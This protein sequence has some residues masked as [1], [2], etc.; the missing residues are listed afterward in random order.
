MRNLWWATCHNY[1][2]YRWILFLFSASRSSP[3]SL[4]SVAPAHR[5][6]IWHF[7]NWLFGRFQLSGSMKMIHAIIFVPENLLQG[8]FSDLSQYATSELSLKLIEIKHITAFS[9]PFKV[10]S[11]HADL[12][13]AT[14]PLGT[15][16]QS[17]MSIAPVLLYAQMPH[18]HAGKMR[19]NVRETFWK[20][21]TLSICSV[22]RGCK[23]H[24][25]DI[26]KEEMRMMS[27][28]LISFSDWS[29]KCHKMTLMYCLEPGM[30]PKS[31]SRHWCSQVV[32]LRTSRPKKFY[33]KLKLN[34]DARNLYSG[35]S[36]KKTCISVDHPISHF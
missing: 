4:N 5:S 31:F 24:S 9:L 2:K 32:E 19:Y 14:A 27:C 3:K 30:N 23:M 12:F 21:G 1:I 17:G 6:I 25:K 13:I 34:T 15:F 36:G 29:I 8:A 20:M 26:E 33:R 7:N 18:S 35:T 28:C 16:K 10:T 22:I 11:G